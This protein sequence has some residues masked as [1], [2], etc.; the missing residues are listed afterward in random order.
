MES[1]TALM[2]E[3]SKKLELAEKSR[4][5]R[6]FDRAETLCRE[7][8]AKHPDYVGALQTLGL[9][10]ADM[11]KFDQS[12]DYLSRA[13]S[14]NPKDW[15]ILTALSGSHLRNGATQ[16]A[17]I[18]LEQAQRLKP[19]DANILATLGEVYREEREY[20]M[21]AN[22]HERAFTIDPSLGVARIGY[23]HSC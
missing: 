17:A 22:A 23:G 18:T 3:T 8:L 9:T 1:N 4:L 14:L 2:V 16:M 10:L 12:C 11:Q 21:A 19:D 15:K 7:L 20:E 5:A 6:Q 13:A